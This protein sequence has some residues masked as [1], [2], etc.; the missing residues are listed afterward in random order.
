LADLAC[1]LHIFADDHPYTFNM[2]IQFSCLNRSHEVL[3]AWIWDWMPEFA[4]C[5]VIRA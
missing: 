2:N 5:G 3:P 1:L 4:N